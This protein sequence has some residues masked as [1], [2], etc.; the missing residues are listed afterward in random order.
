MMFP[1][2]VTRQCAD[3][4][5]LLGTACFPYLHSSVIN[6][7]GKS[8]YSTY[9]AALQSDAKVAIAAIEMA[10]MQGC[11]S[12]LPAGNQRSVF[13]IPL[14][15][16]GQ[17]PW[18]AIGRCCEPPT[19]LGK[20]LLRVAAEANRRQLQIDSQERAIINA[21]LDMERSQL[22]RAWLRQ[23]NAQRAIRKK[24]VGQQSRQAIDSLRN[25]IHAD[26]I[27]I[28]LYPDHEAAN[29]GLQSMITGKTNWTLDDVRL[30]LNRFKMP[31]CG[32]SVILS[33]IDHPL[34]NGVL[35]DCVIVPI[36]EAA[37]IG[38][39]IAINR[40]IALAT[41]QNQSLHP[42]ENRF[43]AG[44]AELLHVVAGYLSA[45]GF[46]NAQLLESEQLVLGTLRAMSNAI[47]ARDPYTHGHSERVGNVGYK[48]A[49][50]LHLSEISCQEI[51]LAGVL[52]DIGKIGIPDNVLLKPGR[53][54][55]EE[56][57]IIQKHPE[58]GHRILEDLGKLKFALP[59]VLYHHERVDGRGYPHQLAGEE[60][61]LMSRI[62]AVSDAYDAMTSSRVYRNAMGQQRAVEILKNGM[63]SQ[64]D[65]DVVEACVEY[66]QDSTQEPIA[67][68]PKANTDWRQ[69]S[70]ALRVLQL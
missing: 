4:A 44:D 25:L 48:I 46:S 67:E 16:M 41:T 47:E 43:H 3:L 5:Q 22:E 32:N 57:A 59:G 36:G 26:A 2:V 64:W 10:S 69:I 20:K 13:A 60:I 68:F 42:G 33:E 27:A 17:E 12:L 31:A 7:K 19:P 63:N 66:I 9:E 45:D 24:M 37:P 70:K 18:Y 21:E 30:L 62:L 53:L 6:L 35:S 52:H 55:P 54:E 38:F 65:A 40:R 28:Y 15:G 50:R 49:Q 8:V 1:A 14:T 58:I 29:H 51:Y 11:E 61:P 34:Q 56:L 39:V 23:L